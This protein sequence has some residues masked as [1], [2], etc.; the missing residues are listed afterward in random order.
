MEEKTYVM[1]KPDG[2]HRGLVG[3]IIQRFEDKGMALIGLK[4]MQ[5]Q[6]ALLEEHYE[7]LKERPFFPALLDYIGSGPVVCMCW[8]GKDAPNTARTL[9]G[10]T[11]PLKA[12]NGTIRGDF[13]QVSGRNVVHGSDSM[14]SA[15]RELALW[16]AEGEILQWQP[17]MQ[18]WIHGDN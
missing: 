12:G 15:E 4:M 7:E 1:I 13:G 3:K 6:P 16:F 9:I 5:A 17:A 8:A 2:V 11:D 18:A 10:A 14:A